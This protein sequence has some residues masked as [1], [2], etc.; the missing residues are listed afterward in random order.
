M[1]RLDQT[2]INACISLAHR[3]GSYRPDCDDWCAEMVE[4]RR[5]L[6]ALVKKKRAFVIPSDA[7][8]TYELTYQGIADAEASVA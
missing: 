8:P 5:V 1:K 4:V 3:G 7:G 2:E 6:D